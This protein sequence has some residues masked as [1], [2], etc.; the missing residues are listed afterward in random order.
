MPRQQ[1]DTHCVTLAFQFSMSYLSNAFIR[2]VFNLVM[3]PKIG[4]RQSRNWLR[5]GYIQIAN[6]VYEKNMR[7][8]CQIKI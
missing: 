7:Y 4:S 8:S 5:S 3:F 6:L 1:G 2:Y